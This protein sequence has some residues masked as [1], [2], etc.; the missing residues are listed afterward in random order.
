MSRI[1]VMRTEGE[2]APTVEH[3]Q[4]PKEIYILGATDRRRQVS[5]MRGRE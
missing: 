3:G 4:T 1:T 5:R 2:G